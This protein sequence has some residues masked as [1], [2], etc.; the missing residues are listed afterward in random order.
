MQDCQAESQVYLSPVESIASLS[1]FCLLRLNGGGGGKTFFE[2][3]KRGPVGFFEP[4]HGSAPDIAGKGIA[5]PLA[6]I[7]SVEMLLRYGLQLTEEADRVAAAV[8]R[9]LAD[10]LRS[11]DIMQPGCQQLDTAAMAD[12]VIERL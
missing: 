8:R 12:A 3:G 11:A 2:G 9:T 4:I 1:E 7:G 6:M 5:N 10:G